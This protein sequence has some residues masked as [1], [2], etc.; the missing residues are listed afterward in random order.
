MEGV[1]VGP[2]AVG[3]RFT[4]ADAC[5]IPFVQVGLPPCRRVRVLCACAAE[6]LARAVVFVCVCVCVVCVCDV[7]SVCVCAICVRLPASVSSVSVGTPPK[8]LEKEFAVL[9]EHE[10][11]RKWYDAVQELDGVRETLR[12]SWWWWW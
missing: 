9:K 4:I 2:F 8:R 12:S 5:A 7:V 3:E 10:K 1:L 11:L 6:P